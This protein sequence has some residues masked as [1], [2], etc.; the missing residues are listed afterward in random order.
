V[1]ARIRVARMYRNNI[2]VMTNM[3]VK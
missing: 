2:Q 3:I 1:P